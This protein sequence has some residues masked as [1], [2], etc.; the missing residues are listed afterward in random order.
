M[1]SPNSSEI[2]V[3]LARYLA[4]EI[5]LRAF[6][7]WFVP[8]TWGIRADASPAAWK[9]SAKIT[10]RLAEYSRGDWAEA[11]LKGLLQPL[12]ATTERNVFLRTHEERLSTSPLRITLSASKV[13]VSVKPV[14]SHQ[15]VEAS[16]SRTVSLSFTL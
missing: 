3:W 1:E 14:L 16:P 7:T 9:I 13:C 12:I 11:E 5:T 2:R 4:G 6:R 10:H 8:A 15:P